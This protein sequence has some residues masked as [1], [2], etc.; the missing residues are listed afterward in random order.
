ME[1][2]KNNLLKSFI[3]SSKLAILCKFITFPVG[4][5]VASIIGSEGY[6]LLGIITVTAQFVAYGNFGILNG[7]NRE[8]P[9]AKGLKSKEAEVK[10]YNAI[11]TF[12]FLSSV[13]IFISVA[14]IFYISGSLFKINELGMVILIILIAV[15]SSV[16][17]FFYNSIKGENQLKLWANFV[18]LRPLIDSLSGLVLVIFFGFNGLII[19]II[20]SKILASLILRKSYIGPKLRL[21]LSFKIIEILKTTTF[22]MII[23]FIKTYFVK[24]PIFLT[25][26]I[27][28][29]KLIGVITFG[30]ANFFVAEKFAGS[31]IFAVN[32]KNEFARNVGENKSERH[33]KYYLGGKNFFRHNL[34]NGVLGGALATLYNFI[35]TVFLQDFTMILPSIHTIASFYFVWTIVLFLHQLFDVLR[36]LYIKLL[37]IAT[38]A[39]FF[40]IIIFK[41]SFDQNIHQILNYYLLS[42]YIILFLT[43]IFFIYL[44]ASKYIAAS[45]LRTIVITLSFYFSLKFS[46]SYEFKYIIFSSNFFLTEFIKLVFSYVLFALLFGFSIFILYKSEFSKLTL[47]IIDKINEK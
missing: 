21:E 10:I 39:S 14:L 37:I 36:Y 5:Y 19:S 25:T 17:G 38:G 6:G 8:L 12:L 27:L 15:S 47:E 35:I 31:Q 45:F 33:A 29:T 22:L 32:Q 2:Q 42:S 24:A 34:F 28:S 26:S 1:A 3:D 4:I 30:I 16:E 23:N 41:L 46:I 18:T 11:F 9:I 7:L 40:T 20:F 13:F 43:F 44:D